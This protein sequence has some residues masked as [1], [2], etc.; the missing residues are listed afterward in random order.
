MARR[1]KDLQFAIRFGVSADHPRCVHVLDRGASRKCRKVE[2]ML[3]A[4]SC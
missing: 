1:L 2:M 4:E 3:L